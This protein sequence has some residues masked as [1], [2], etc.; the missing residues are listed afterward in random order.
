M[1]ALFALHGA[2]F[3]ARLDGQG[4][5]RDFRMWNRAQDW[6]HVFYMY[7]PTNLNL[8]TSAC[9]AGGRKNNE[10]MTFNGKQLAALVKMGVTMA[11]VDGKIADEEQNAM[12][13]ELL[14]FGV[15]QDQVQ[16]LLISAQTMKAD[17]AIGILSSM[18]NEQKKYATGYLA[19]IMVSDGNIEDEEVKM[20]QLICT[21]CSFPTM[22]V[23][24]A[25]NFWNRN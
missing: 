11:A 8:L 9:G 12:V 13:L 2:F 14:N 6:L 7:A 10:T 19:V 16:A 5:T 21:I 23:Y 15:K 1:V 3:V 18:D 17:E 22:N 20:W 4:N 25:L 24:E